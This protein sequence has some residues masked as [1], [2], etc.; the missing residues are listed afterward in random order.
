MVISV[1][2]PLG[3]FGNSVTLGSSPTTTQDIIVG[4]N[5]DIDTGTVPEDIWNGGGLYTGQ[6]VNTVQAVDVS[7][8]S[9]NDTLGGTGANTIIIRGLASPTSETYTTEIINL[10]GLTPV[11]STNA[12]Y[13]V[14]S[15]R[16]TSAGSL[17]NADGSITIQGNTNPLNVFGVID[18][19]YNRT[20]NAVY[21]V[22]NKRQLN[23]DDGILSIGRSTGAPGSATVEGKVRPFGGVYETEF[24]FSLTD[25]GEIEINFNLL[26]TVSPQADIIFQVTDVSDSNTIATATLV[27][28]LNQV[29]N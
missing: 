17:N 15:A 11:T 22:P 23:I 9:A 26:G 13:R 29:G 1:Y 6:P 3:D 20:L 28:L 16:V 8:V 2:N 21:T 7:S 18:P 25:S 27:F 14:V 12:Y 24:V 5:T 19:L 10:N 4:V